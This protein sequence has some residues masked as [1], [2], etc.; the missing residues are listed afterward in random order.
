MWI[1]IG[2]L[3]YFYFDNLPPLVVRKECWRS[4]RSIPQSSVSCMDSYGCE[5][6][7]WPVGVEIVPV[8][9][10]SRGGGVGYVQK[11]KQLK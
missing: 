2:T 6:R 3:H 5:K 10:L 11:L 9:I 1:E 7:K 8:D 4:S